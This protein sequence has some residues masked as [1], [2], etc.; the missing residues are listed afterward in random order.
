RGFDH[1]VFRFSP[2]PGEE[3]QPLARAASGG[4]LSRVYLALQ[5][6]AGLDREA[7]PALVFDE[8]DVGVGGAQAEALGRKLKRLARGGQIL[9]V[10]HSPQVASHGDLHFRVTKRVEG[11]RTWASV[12]RL[13]S[14]P[15]VAEL[16]RMLAGKRVTALSLEHAQEMLE[17]AERRIR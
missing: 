1:V 17:G 10:T 15:R 11:G 16:A 13:A 4:E 6:A 3:L 12:E 2:N 5:L 9:A 8:V 14:K 7:L